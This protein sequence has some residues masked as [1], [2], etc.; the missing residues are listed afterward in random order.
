MNWENT[1]RLI[2]WKAGY[3]REEESNCKILKVIKKK[4]LQQR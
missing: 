3:K 1:G 2:N 4:K